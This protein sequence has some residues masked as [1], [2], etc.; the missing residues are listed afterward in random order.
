MNENRNVFHGLILSADSARGS[1]GSRLGSIALRV[2]NHPESIRYLLSLLEGVDPN[3]EDILYNAKIRNVLQIAL[4]KPYQFIEL[5]M[6]LETA[7]AIHKGSLEYVEQ[8][9]YGMNYALEN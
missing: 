2:S 1:L 6:S 3:I 7:H 4:K 5:G 9:K 8:S